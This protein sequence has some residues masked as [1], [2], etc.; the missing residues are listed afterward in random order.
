[1]HDTLQRISGFD[2]L[3]RRLVSFHRCRAHQI[4]PTRMLHHDPRATGSILRPLSRPT[5]TS[6]ESGRRGPGSK[7]QTT[8]HGEVRVGIPRVRQIP[9]FW[10]VRIHIIVDPLENSAANKI[11]R[12][13]ARQHKLAAVSVPLQCRSN[14]SVQTLR[15]LSLEGFPWST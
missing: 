9:G 11:G 4:E 10:Q 5:G 8:R 7:E 15:K 14:T 12:R 2:V 6:H 1:M 13:H 3:C